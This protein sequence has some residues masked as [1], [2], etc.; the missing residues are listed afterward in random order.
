M[1]GNQDRGLLKPTGVRNWSR[2]G[3]GILLTDLFS[4]ACSCCFY[5]YQYRPPV[6]LGTRS[7]TA[8]TFSIVLLELFLWA[9]PD[10][11][12]GCGCKGRGVGESARVHPEF[13]CSGRADAGGLPDAFH[14]AL[15]GHLVVWSH[16]SHTA[17]GCKRG[18]P[19]YQVLSLRHPILDTVEELGGSH[20]GDSPS[21]GPL[22][23]ET[24]YG[25]R[26]LL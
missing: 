23:S 2:G 5:I 11:V 3:G 17:G 18:S 24:V 12:Q 19:W 26:I 4:M 16:W 6:V 21:S 8:I 20:A 15:S 14:A 22:W 9:S 1:K 10:Q 7:E 25:F 13:L